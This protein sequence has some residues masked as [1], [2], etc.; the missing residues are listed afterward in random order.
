M[1]KFSE[2]LKELRRAKRLSQQEFSK[3][4]GVS[5][6]SINMYE[7]GE[8]EPS[9]D[10]IEAIADFF[11]VDLDYL[12][13]KSD[14]Q[15]KTRLDNIQNKFNEFSPTI[16]D[17]FTTFPVIGE[18]AAGYEHIAVED[19]E[20]DKIDIPTSWL[21]GRASSEY[22]VL[23][24]KGDSM[25]PIYH[26]GDKVLVLRQNT[27]DYSGQIGVIIYESENV[28]VKKIEYKHGEDWMRLVPVNPN[29][30]QVRIENADLERCHVLGIPRI[31][32]RDIKD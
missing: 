24:I 31:L 25:F 30:P 32:I 2:R 13:G 18:V 11:N 16:T 3:Y 22:F 8:R 15:N 12:L 19:W 5:K 26:D 1:L 29:Y 20:G 27:M 7:R 21:E 23:K 17:D 6:S 9:L 14:I 28:T 4:I 10:T